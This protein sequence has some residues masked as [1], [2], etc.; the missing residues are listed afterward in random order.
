M[1]A[2]IVV[3]GSIVNDDINPV[4]GIAASK[5]QCYI[6]KIYNQVSDTVIVD[7]KPIPIHIVRG[8]SMTI[9]S[10]TASW[11]TQASQG[12]GDD[13]HVEVD[14]F[15]DGTTVMSGGELDIVTATAS[16][17]L[18]EGTITDTTHEKNQ[19]VSVDI[20]ALGSQGTQGKG[21]IV[22]VRMVETFPVS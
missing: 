15:V 20:D 13:M 11:T 17:G 18:V 6:A 19:V 4:A 1:G 5:S 10:I 7:S 22:E 21:L 2:S 12:G 8:A 14:V 9:L 3:T 16:N